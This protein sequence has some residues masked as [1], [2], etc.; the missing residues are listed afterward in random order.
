MRLRFGDVL[1]IQGSVDAINRLQ[2]ETD[3]I[4]VADSRAMKRRR[5]SASA[6]AS[7]TTDLVPDN[8]ELEYDFVNDCWVKNTMGTETSSSHVAASLPSPKKKK[9]QV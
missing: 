7:A 9:K 4:S 6:S 1:L 5:T 3:F 8:G 2:N